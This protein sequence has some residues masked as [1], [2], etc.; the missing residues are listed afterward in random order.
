M[1]R[2]PCRHLFFIIWKM[3]DFEGHKRF[4][5]IDKTDFNYFSD[6]MNTYM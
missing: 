4:E 6:E 2:E 3:N 5:Q 1:T